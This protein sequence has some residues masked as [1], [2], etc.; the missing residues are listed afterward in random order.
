MSEK[1][2]FSLGYPIGFINVNNEE[3]YGIQLNDNMYPVNLLSAF[4]WLEALKGGR[5]K[6]DIM[7]NVLEDL[8]KQGYELGKDF[9]LENLET[10]YSGL[11]SSSLLIEV[12]NNGLEIFLKKYP[13]IVPFRAGFGLGIESNKIKIHN[14]SRNIEIT[15]IEYYIWQLSNGSRTLNVMYE[16][17]EKGYKM[18][19]SNSSSMANE[20]AV[21]DLK[22]VFMDAFVELYKKNLIYVSNI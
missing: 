17:Y 21:E 1:M 8:Q 3:Y 18:A 7:D 19:L 10:V 22:R 11:L 15:S 6:I 9:T 4:I 13:N 16:E 20:Y 12:D 2:I 14:E 5:T